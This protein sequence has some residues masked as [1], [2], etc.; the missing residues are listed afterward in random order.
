MRKYNTSKLLSFF[1]LILFIVSA[2]L[3]DKGPKFKNI[4]I[5]SLDCF[6]S[7]KGRIKLN[8]NSIE[9]K[10][11]GRALILLSITRAC[12]LFIKSS[13]SAKN[14]SLV[15]FFVATVIYLGIWSKNASKNVFSCT[16]WLLFLPPI[17]GLN[18]VFFRNELVIIE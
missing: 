1:L 12:F 14:L 17:Y 11:S 18:L 7:L 13:N 3:V 16:L 9:T 10:W 15:C 4:F 6:I 5:I 8:A 2:L